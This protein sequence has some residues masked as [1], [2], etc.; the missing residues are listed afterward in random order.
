MIEI[1]LLPEGLKAKTANVQEKQRQLLYLASA[2]I[3]G[4]LLFSYLLLLLMYFKKSSVLKGLN[5]KWVALAQKRNSIEEFKRK[6]QVSSVSE[7]LKKEKVSEGPSCCSK[8]LARISINLAKG[9]WLSE[10]D[11]KEEILFLRGSALSLEKE[12]VSLIH[13]F[14]SN[15]TNDKEFNI[16]FKDIELGPLSRRVLGAYDILDFTLEAKVKKR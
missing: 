15:L 6:Y 1:N 7:V 10:L 14:I 9:L 13:K 8:N 3:I 16:D 12:E 11:F 5:K 2:I 4:V